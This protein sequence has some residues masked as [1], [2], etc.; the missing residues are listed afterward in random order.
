MQLAR[1]YDQGR[2][3]DGMTPYARLAFIVIGVAAI[4]GAL[5]AVFPVN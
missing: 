1:I 3:D 5:W 4:F 2:M